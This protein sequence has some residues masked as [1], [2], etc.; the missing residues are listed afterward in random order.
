ML[1]GGFAGLAA[2]YYY[3]DAVL[4]DRY[5][6]L[7]M[8]PNLVDVV[9]T[10]RTE[11]AMVP[12]KVDVRAEVLKVDIDGKKVV[13]DKGVFDYD[14]LVLSLGYEQDLSKVPGA[15]VNA[16]KLETLNDALTLR[17]KIERAKRVVI[18]GGGDLGVELAGSTVELA[19]RLRGREVTLVNHG[20]RLLPHMP[21]RISRKVEDLLSSKVRLLLGQKVEEVREGEVVLKDQVLR[22]DLTIYA[23]GLRGPPIL[24]NLP[25]SRREGKVLVRRNLS[26]VDRDDVYAAGACADGIP[27]NGQ[28]AIDSGRI[29]IRNAVGEGSEEYKPRPIVD[30][31]KVEEECFGAI[32][33]VPLSGGVGCLLR[34]LA[35]FNV[36]RMAGLLNLR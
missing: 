10:G 18:V 21:P 7:T 31:V 5:D 22:T 32:G 3:R 25:L 15:R 30:V 9:V 29:A 24:S 20:E 23:G 6:Y 11:V 16:L 4:V 12:R 13:T 34:S 27:S 8:T 14:K 28:A 35:Y 1:G 19:S 17:A 33:E 36:M 26:S 2:K